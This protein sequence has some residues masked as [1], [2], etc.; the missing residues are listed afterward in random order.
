M[1][2]MSSCLPIGPS[3]SPRQQAYDWYASAIERPQ[4]PAIDRRF[5]R[6]TDRLAERLWR[7]CG[8]DLT[9]LYFSAGL[10]RLKWMRVR[11][12][13]WRAAQLGKRLE[14]I[15]TIDGLAARFAEVLPTQLGRWVVAR[16]LFF[17]LDADLD[18]SRAFQ[19]ERSY[20]RSLIGSWR[21][22]HPGEP[23][24][25]LIHGLEHE[26][27]LMGHLLRALRAR[28]LRVAERRRDV[29]RA[30]RL[31]APGGFAQLT[32][33]ELRAAAKKAAQVK[34][35]PVYLP[36]EDAKILEL[37]AD[38]LNRLSPK[39]LG[40]K[41]IWDAFQGWRQGIG[42]GARR[43][44]PKSLMDRYRNLAGLDRGPGRSV[45]PSS[46]DETGTAPP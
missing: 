1:F 36:A 7:V 15:H 18:S 3:P 23:D 43:L 16:A 35:C 19:L 9:Q 25:S 29:P 21:K 6:S 10:A 45:V 37:A 31:G 24:T 14:D 8:D 22:F 17:W 32:P 40:W 5:V 44:Q 26:Q 27:R 13:E 39:R 2:V 33:D 38:P 34:G 42:L 11:T 41:Q 30:P 12:D 4:S 46:A 20:R 28:Q